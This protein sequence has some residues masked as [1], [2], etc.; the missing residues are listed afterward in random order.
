MYKIDT[1]LINALLEYLANRPYREVFQLI[2]ALQRLEKIEEEK[3]DLK[4]KRK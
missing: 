1:N 3:K 2:N 4:T